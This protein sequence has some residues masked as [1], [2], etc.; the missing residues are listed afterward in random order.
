MCAVVFRGGVAEEQCKP[1]TLLSSGLQRLAGL[2]ELPLPLRE[3]PPPVSSA[4]AYRGWSAGST[5]SLASSKGILLAPDYAKD[6]AWTDGGH[7]TCPDRT[8]G[9]L[10]AQRTSP[11]APGRHAHAPTRSRSAWRSEQARRARTK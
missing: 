9:W 7:H 4:R 6:S 2:S 8:F 10:S 11:P 3:E 1:M 5:P